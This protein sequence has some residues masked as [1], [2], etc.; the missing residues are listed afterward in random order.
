MDIPEED[1]AQVA[2]RKAIQ[3][4][5]R[6]AALNPQEKQKKIQQYMATG[7]PAASA[8]PANP[9]P[10]SQSA[11]PP[12]SQPPPSVAPATSKHAMMQ[13]VVR[14][15]SLTPDQKQQRIQQIVA[16][17]TPAPAQEVAP[18]ADAAAPLSASRQAMMDV[19]RDPNLTPQEKQQRVQQ[20]SGGGARPGP[21]P[22]PPTVHSTPERPSDSKQAI[23]SIMK[24]DS[25]TSQEKQQ[26]VQQIMASGVPP[27][28]AT[29]TPSSQSSAPSSNSSAVVSSVE[30]DAISKS[31]ARNMS[32]ATQPG[33]TPSEPPRG[34]P[35]NAAV[36]SLAEQDAMAKN[37]GSGSPQPTAMVNMER[38]IIAKVG[39]ANA[40]SSTP[41]AV[42]AVDGN[43]YGKGPG[44]SAQS[45][46]GAVSSTNA[47][48]ASRKAARASARAGAASAVSTESDPATRNA[49]LPSTHS[50]ADTSVASSQ[51]QGG[52]GAPGAAASSGVDPASRKN[53][54]SLATTP[55]ASSNSGVDPASRKTER[56]SARPTAAVAVASSS[57]PVEDK[58]QMDIRQFEDSLVEKTRSIP[59]PDSNPSP[60]DYPGD[61]YVQQSSQPEGPEIAS[62]SIIPQSTY[63]EPAQSYDGGREIVDHSPGPV[64]AS[65][66][67]P[68]VETP[69]YAGLNYDPANIVGAEEGG[70]QVS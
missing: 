21:D 23:T 24:D 66:E 53:A 41:G 28:A 36:T 50:V 55:G 47:D 34:P 8:A 15:T 49:A 35:S 29:P 69:A 39:T 65:P 13:E 52:Y 38:D 59:P 63:E 33:A 43:Q 32:R 22:D 3:T 40:A 26:R 64:A 5:M 1:N 25:L 70:L 20:I 56:A 31:R 27:P 68:T 61:G 4:I 16:G 51:G 7:G 17:D 2:K 11:P 48:P 18:P 10:P 44:R 14:D 30:R 6:D 67:A 58:D 60:Q 62:V 12:Q 9:P 46:V 45:Q 19:M 57:P 54:R 37:H 42:S